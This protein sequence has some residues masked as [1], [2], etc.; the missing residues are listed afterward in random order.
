MLSFK[1]KPSSL[2]AILLLTLAATATATGAEI[3]T[4]VSPDDDFAP[5]LFIFAIVAGGVLLILIGIGI[6]IGLVS[7]ACTGL[8]VALGIVSSSALVAVLTRRLS[9]GLRAFHYQMAAAISVPCGITAMLFCGEMLK[10]Q[11]RFRD[12]LLL[13]SAVGIAAGLALAFIL[14]RPVRAAYRGLV[15]RVR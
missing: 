13:G 2:I 11:M 10:W 3:P 1:L 4:A 5:G 7:A 6:V 14:D 15:K 9:T 8:L 12:V